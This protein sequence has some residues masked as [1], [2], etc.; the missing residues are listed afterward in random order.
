MCRDEVDNQEKGKRDLVF[1]AICT[2]YTRLDP[3]VDL[4]NWPGEP[5]GV[6]NLIHALAN[7][8]LS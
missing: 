2:W 3:P 1:V 5:P 8:V 7:R 4:Q 6:H